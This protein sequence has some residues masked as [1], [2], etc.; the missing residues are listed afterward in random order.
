MLIKFSFSYGD[1][2]PKTFLGR[3]YIIVWTLLGLAITGIVT[4]SLTSS[5]NAVSVVAKVKYPEN[6]VSDF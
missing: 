3:V 6:K 2:Y 5:L 1:K 4:G